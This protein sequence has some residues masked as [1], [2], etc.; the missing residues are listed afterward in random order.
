MPVEVDFMFKQFAFL[1]I[2]FFMVLYSHASEMCISL[3]E[4]CVNAGGDAVC[5]KIDAKCSCKALLDSIRGEREWRENVLAGSS[6]NL[7]KYFMDNCETDFC[8]FKVTI[9]SGSFKKAKKTDLPMTFEEVRSYIDTAR[10]E[11]KV[12][13]LDSLLLDSLKTFSPDCEDFCAMCPGSKAA[14]KETP[15]LCGEIEQTCRCAHFAELKEN[16]AEK[17]RSDSI[18][19]A[20]LQRERL[21]KALVAARNIVEQCSEKRCNLLITLQKSK[22]KLIFIREEFKAKKKKKAEA[23]P[24]KKK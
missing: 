2:L 22:M 16:V 23:A 17:I 9:D 5:A 21:E 24:V 18:Q 14:N 6:H 1:S 13:N 15:P 7:A 12:N 10:N 11:A 4:K 20:T 8:A 19:T 3:C